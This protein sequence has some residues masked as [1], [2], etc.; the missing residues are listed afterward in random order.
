MALVKCPE[1]GKLFS[2]KALSCPDCA[3]P[4]TVA[5]MVGFG[6]IDEDKALD[7]A[8]ELLE[9]DDR[10]STEE[11]LEIFLALAEKDSAKGQYEAGKIYLYEKDGKNI[12]K[13]I[14]LLEK[15]VSSSL[16]FGDYHIAEFF[17][18]NNQS[19]NALKYFNK[20][21]KN[22]G[23]SKFSDEEQGEIL[24]FVS[25][26]EKSLKEKI[27]LL[28][29]SLEKG[30]EKSKNYLVGEYLLDAKKCYESGRFEEAKE[31]LSSPV[32]SE[33]E[34]GKKLL[35]DVYIS[36]SKRTDNS[37]KRENY[38]NKSA[39]LGNEEARGILGEFYF[40]S[41]G[42][43]LD[44]EL[45]EKSAEYGNKEA[46]ERLSDYYNKQG[47]YYSEADNKDYEKSLEH[48]EKAINYGSEKAKSNFGKVCNMWGYEL[49][50]EENPDYEKAEELFNNAIAC[51]NK[52]AVKNLGIL[53]NQYGMM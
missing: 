33:N 2:H 53:Y 32:L 36:L 49:Y 5:D 48:L 46:S 51:G 15:S 28:Q 29:L 47:I 21:Y 26:G 43:D 40:C 19:E 35:S 11:A 50:S 6:V 8:S 7:A 27:N 17:Y 3:Y 14:E 39:S 4:L 10:D 38:L 24:F 12:N 25:T 13:G 22:K 45:L 42:D 18:K 16:P 44:I 52:N 34:E 23:F 30:F 37:R 20:C 41:M 1:C 31:I 9:K